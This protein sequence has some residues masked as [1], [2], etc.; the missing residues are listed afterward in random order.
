MLRSNRL[1][2]PLDH[3]RSIR[4][5]ILVHGFDIGAISGA[6]QEWGTFE[7]ARTLLSA[8]A[9]DACVTLFPVSTNLRHL[10][11]DVPFWMHE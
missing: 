5:G 1:D 10:D 9:K 7:R 2:F 6:D 4:D 3:P 11:D 8:V